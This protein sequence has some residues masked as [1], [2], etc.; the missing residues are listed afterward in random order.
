MGNNLLIDN[1]LLQDVGG[2]LSGGLSSDDASELVIEHSNNSHSFQDV[3]LAGVQIEALL[4]F[5][6]DIVLRDSIIVD[7]GFTDAWLDFENNLSILLTNGLMR[8]LPL[9]EY[10]DQLTDPRKYAV[11]Q[12]CVT[13]SLLDAQHRN[14]ESWANIGIPDDQYMSQII[15]G[16]AGMLSR[17]HIFEAPYSGHPMRKRVLDQTILSNKPRNAVNE[18]LAWITNER[19]RLFDVMGLNGTQRTAS[20]VLP[21]IAIEIIEESQDIKDLVSVA[22]QL[23]EKYSS[24]REWMKLVQDAME[25]EDSGGIAKYKRTLNTVAKDLD[26]AIDGTETGTISLTIGW[27]WPS[28][29]IPVSLDGVR[30]KFGIRAVLNNQIFSPKGVRS[31]NKLLR[32]FGEE[33]S[34]IGL[35][36]QEYLRL[37]H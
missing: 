17:S 1:W 9:Y 3:P 6:V 14:E 35:S 16:T 29:S 27:G 12:L 2:C 30:K 33:K 26:K 5:L 18:T 19:L 24:L 7:S 8:S 21:P 23:R 22:Y 20:L 37:I 28:I 13:T 31:L 36:V 10:E 32:M 25:S 34:S 15:W 4:G 11:K